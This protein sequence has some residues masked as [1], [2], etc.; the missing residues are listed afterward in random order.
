MKTFASLVLAATLAVAASGQT[1]INGQGATFPDPMY[2]KWFSEYKKLHSDVQINY[3]PTGSGAG[4]KAVTE[5]T[6]DFGGSDAVMSEDELK[7]YKDKHGGSDV[8]AFPT[9]MGAV[10]VTYNVKGVAGALNLTGPALAAIYL[11]KITKWNDP[12]LVK[13]N[14]GI[15]LPKSDI[16]VVHRSDGSGTSYCFTDY[17]AKVSPEWLMKVGKAASV[18]WPVGLGGAKNEG[19]AGLIGQQANSIGYVELAFAVQNKLTYA[20]MQNASGAFVKPSLESVTAAATGAAK[21]MPEDFRV[22][23]TNA[24]GKDAYPISTFTWL[25]IPSQFAAK[26]AAKK[27]ALTDFLGWM[28]KDGQAMTAPL[29]YA[30]LPKEVVAKEVKAIAKIK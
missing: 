27:K 4:I 19:V 8:L 30:A 7:A 2:T 16:V 15:N 14:P 17:L 24:P 9:V 6:A 10:V 21:T 11:G 28:L 20:S 18:S 23:I 26:D 3:T 5:G 22:S 12:E 25:L 1:L 29:T 13:A